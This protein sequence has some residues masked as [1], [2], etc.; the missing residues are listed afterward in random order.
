MNYRDL[1]S[2]WRQNVKN[3]QHMSWFNRIRYTP[4]LLKQNIRFQRDVDRQANEARLSID[5]IK[6]GHFAEDQNAC[7]GHLPQEYDEGTS[8]SEIPELE[9]RLKEIVTDVSGEYYVCMKCGQFWK[10]SVC[11]PPGGKIPGSH[12]Y[13]FTP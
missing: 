6:L 1:L 11:F 8:L 4:M 10:C 2:M 7:C 9:A 3:T 5:R 12:V 13:K